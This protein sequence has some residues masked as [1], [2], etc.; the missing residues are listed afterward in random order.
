MKLSS[1]YVLMIVYGKIQSDPRAIRNAEA[2]AELNIPI[3]VLSCNS[4]ANYKNDKFQSIIYTSKNKGIISLM[5]F[6]AYIVK[7]CLLY[8]KDIK[9]LY[10]NNYYL[11]WVSCV[12]CKIIKK[13]W[14]YDAYELLIQ[15][16][17]YKYSK[18]TLFFLLT[19][20]FSIKKSSLVIEANKERERI[21][22]TLYKLSNTTFVQNIAPAPKIN[23]SDELKKNIIVYQG[24]MCEERRLQ[25]YI[26][27]MQYLP[28]NIFFKLIGEGPDLYT[29]KKLVNDY[30]LE[31]RIIFTGQLA[32][33]DLYKESISA[34]VG[35]VSYIMNDTNCY[36]CAPNK[37]FEYAQMHIAA[38]VTPQ[39]ALKEMVTKYCIGEVIEEKDDDRILASKLQ[40]MIENYDIYHAGMQ[41][42]LSNNNWDSEKKRLQKEIKKYLYYES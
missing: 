30:S 28:E 42:F 33:S 34:K 20:R 16:K 29:Y 3:R 4:D 2:I 37:I 5:C 35:I 11:A 36:Y 27:A 32:Y 22:R 38:L 6:W 13:K 8:H 18:R 25:R 19:E 9:W 24:Y 23:I 7:Y 31:D 17:G 12:I 14:I 21:I 26:R 10:V 15:R 39:P 1:K 41:S 40:N